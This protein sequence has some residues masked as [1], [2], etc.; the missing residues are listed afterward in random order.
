VNLGWSI[1][2]S[3]KDLQL[4]RSVSFPASITLQGGKPDVGC[5]SAE[6]KYQAWHSSSYITCPLPGSTT[7]VGDRWNE[8]GDK[9]KLPNIFEDK[10]DRALRQKKEDIFA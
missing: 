1:D 4:A 7:L 9:S 3:F 10:N 8:K 6:I 2:I 5:S